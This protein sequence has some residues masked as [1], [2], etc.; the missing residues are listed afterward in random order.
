MYVLSFTQIPLHQKRHF[1]YLKSDEGRS[2]R[3]QLSFAV[4][5]EAI[6]K[7]I[8]IERRDVKVLSTK[9][10]TSRDR[11]L[12]DIYDQRKLSDKDIQSVFDGAVSAYRETDEQACLEDSL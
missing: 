7:T 6:N 12:N 11:E 8:I 1:K 2:L 10:N 5:I 3:D 4:A 9:L